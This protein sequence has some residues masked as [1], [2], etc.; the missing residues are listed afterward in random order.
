MT[1]TKGIDAV[2]HSIRNVKF[3]KRVVRYRL[4]LA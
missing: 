3:V 4:K 1:D 2:F